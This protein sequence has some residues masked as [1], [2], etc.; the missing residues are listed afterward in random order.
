[1]KLPA[2][3]PL[4]PS[5]PTAALADLAL[6]LV[7]Y[8]I[9]ATAFGAD[10]SPVDLPAAPGLYAAPPDAASVVVERR[11]TPASGERLVWRFSNGSEPAHD[12]PGPDALYFEVSRVVDSDPE[13]TFLLR[14][15]GDV[16]Y[17]AVDDVLYWL[18]KAGA[19]N[20]VFGSAVPAP[21]EEP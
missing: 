11:V 8:F 16:R 21:G 17:G 5:V 3:R 1:M 12:L 19:R 20:V 13:K 18:S 7:F 4:S 14:I 2:L 6:L 10:R 9:L 15:D